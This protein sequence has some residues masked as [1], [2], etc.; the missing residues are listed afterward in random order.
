MSGS[1]PPSRQQEPRLPWPDD[2]RR[3]GRA[4][5][6]ST[7]GAVA[8]SLIG[9]PLAG[10]IA[11]GVEGNGWSALTAVLVGA[12]LGAAAC[13]GVA[14][15][16]AFRDESRRSRRTSALVTGIGTLLVTPVA[17]AVLQPLELDW[18]PPQFVL[19]V[20]LLAATVA[21]RVLARRGPPT[22]PATRH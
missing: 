11:Q 15:W 18:L 8:G 10:W 16:I 17:L 4:L 20:V 2:D 14:Q 6:A 1:T 7:A 21:G 5:G 22:G 13:A 12:A 3:I 19:I 9:G